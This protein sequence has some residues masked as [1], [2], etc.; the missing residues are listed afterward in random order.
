MFWIT[1]DDVRLSKLKCT[2]FDAA[3]PPVFEA[4]SAFL[5]RHKLFLPGERRRLTPND[6]APVPLAEIAER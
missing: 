1:A 2:A 3:D 5:A 6:F 4:Q